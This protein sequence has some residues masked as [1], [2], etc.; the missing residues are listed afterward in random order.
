MTEENRKILL[1][2][3][4]AILRNELIAVGLCEEDGRPV[5]RKRLDR[6]KLDPVDIELSELYKRLADFVYQDNQ[7]ATRLNRFNEILGKLPDNYGN[8]PSVVLNLVS[9]ALEGQPGPSAIM[10]RTKAIRILDGI[11][12]KVAAVDK[13]LPAYSYRVAENIIRIVEGR[14]ALDNKLRDKRIESILQRNPAKK[15]SGAA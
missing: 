6:S 7:W 9:L 2:G 14:P 10:L 12:K 13:K 5:K 8:K 4:Y 1:T 11:V 15:E 3:A